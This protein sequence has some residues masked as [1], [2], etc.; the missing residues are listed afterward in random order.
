VLE[1]NKLVAQFQ[2]KSWDNH[3]NS[4]ALRVSLRLELPLQPELEQA[5][6]VSFSPEVSVHNVHQGNL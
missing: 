2:H 3:L 1:V 5:A 6:P 4:H